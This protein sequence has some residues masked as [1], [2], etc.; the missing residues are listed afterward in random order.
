MPGQRGGPS[1]G[2]GEALTWSAEAWTRAQGA[3]RQP[4][5][6]QKGLKDLLAY[7]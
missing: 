7:L 6:L 1:Q 5:V 4:L 3:C 2:R